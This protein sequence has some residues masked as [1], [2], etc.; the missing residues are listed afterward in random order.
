MTRTRSQCVRSPRS[1]RLGLALLAAVLAGIS[2][3]GSAAA[4][5]QDAEADFSAR[6]NLE[7]RAHG[8][9]PLRTSDD[10]VAVARAH[11]ARMAQSRRLEHN[12]HLALEVDEWGRLAE[13]VGV[14]GSVEKIHEALMASE[15]HRRNILNPNLVEVGVGVAQSGDLLWVTQVFRTPAGQP[16]PAA[17]PL[18]SL[19]P[20][21]PSTVPARIPPPPAPFALETARSAT[22]AAEPPM[23][24]G[25]LMASTPMS[26]RA[27][28]APFDTASF[29]S[30]SNGEALRL[31]SAGET[32]GAA[33]GLVAAAALARAGR[34]LQRR[35][36]PHPREGS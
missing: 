23:V 26:T 17:L 13:N 3:S 1:R 2:W 14:G 21:T 32:G 35:V 31:P 34:S 12:T 8:L 36:R 9:P 19:P 6:I 27:L 7:R 18:S 28:V 5:E 25:S 24:P 33:S 11:D 20:L 4:A 29:R 15:E 22:N 16:V 10:L 30:T